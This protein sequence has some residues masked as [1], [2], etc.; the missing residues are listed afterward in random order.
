[1]DARSRNVEHPAAA[2][3][4][5]AWLRVFVLG[6]ILS[7]AAVALGP[8]TQLAVL[9]AATLIC[10]LLGALTCAIGLS[11][12]DPARWR[13][14]RSHVTRV[15]ASLHE[16]TEIVGEPGTVAHARVEPHSRTI[17]RL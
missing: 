17:R 11:L 8:L 15:G 12:Y 5:D 13:E 10:S 14:L 3:W 16:A 2:A 4:F 1:M 9:G 7:L 6:V